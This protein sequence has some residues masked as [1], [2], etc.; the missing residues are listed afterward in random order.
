MFPFGKTVAKS[1]ISYDIFESFRGTFREYRNYSAIMYLTYQTEYLFVIAGRFEMDI[2]NPIYTD[3]E[4]A[5]EH[6]ESIRWPNGPFCPHCGEAEAI[7]KLKG[8]STRPG[9]HKCRSCRKP[10]TVTVGTVF[11]RSKIPLN[12]WV[13]ATHL[14]TA[15]KKGIS[16]HQLHRMLGVTYKTAWF[17]AHRIREAMKIPAEGNPPMGG[18][19]KSVEADET[20]VGRETPGKP[21]QFVS[22]IGWTARRPKRSGHKAV[23]VLVDRETGE[24]RSFHVANVKAKTLRPILFRHVDRASRLQTDESNSYLPT[25]WQFK[26]GHGRVRHKADQYVNGDDYTNTAENFFSVLKR[27]IYGTYQNVSE[28][29]L[30]RYLAEFDFRYSNRDQT[31]FERAER[32]LA[33]IEGKRLT[34]RRPDDAANG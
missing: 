31:D 7:T 6:L 5:R 20:I 33:G 8:K 3:A 9:V 28:A 34:Y 10:F 24:A 1:L 16:A 21:T 26:G 17:M 14:L 18:A 15:S 27:G 19:G 12:K 13:L 2:T 32:A 22:G 4:T 11:E 23:A 30:G 29:H 25:G